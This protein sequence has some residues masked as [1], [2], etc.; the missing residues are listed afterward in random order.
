MQSDI[1]KIRGQLEKD[2][3][4]I[5]GLLGFELDTSTR[6]ISTIAKI[7]DIIHD[8]YLQNEDSG[9]IDGIALQFAAYIV[10]IIEE[11][12]PKGK[13]ERDHEEFGK[14]SFP[15]YLPSGKTI[16]PF[17]WCKKHI[18]NGKQDS[19]KVKFDVFLSNSS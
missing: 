4:K 8:D 9:G 7:L 2:A 10:H 12:F 3:E 5:A 1:N 14:D 15:Y 19:I 17:I 16:F 18:Q 6:A 13:W 11:N